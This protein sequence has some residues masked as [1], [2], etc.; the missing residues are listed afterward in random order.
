VHLPL[1]CPGS[2]GSKWDLP[3]GT[4]QPDLDTRAISDATQWVIG[5][6]HPGIRVYRHR[7]LNYLDIT[8]PRV[9]PF[10]IY[11]AISDVLIFFTPNSG[12]VTQQ[13]PYC[14]LRCPV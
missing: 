5:S 3:I 1:R 9:Y 6:E 8:L 11:V 2:Q 12:W 13:V 7:L 4:P 14:E 10:S